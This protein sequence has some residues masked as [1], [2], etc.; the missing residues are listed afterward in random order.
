MGI[1]KNCD[2]ERTVDMCCLSTEHPGTYFSDLIGIL[3]V[4]YDTVSLPL[5]SCTV[6]LRLTSIRGTTR[7]ERERTYRTPVRS[8]VGEVRQAGRRR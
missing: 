2:R 5:A 4:H 7:H 3:Y 8:H 6:V 1:T